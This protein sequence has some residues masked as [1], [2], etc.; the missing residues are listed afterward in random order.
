MYCM[1]AA[2]ESVHLRTAHN[3]TKM[4][5]CCAENAR[6]STLFRNDVIYKTKVPIC[7]FTNVHIVY[8]VVFLSKFYISSLTLVTLEEL[9]QSARSQSFSL[10]TTVNESSHIVRLW[11]SVKFQLSSSNSFRDMRGSQ[12]YT[13]GGVPHARP[14]AEKNLFP[15]NGIVPRL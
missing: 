9:K 12:I 10:V 8:T 1:N 11:R 7:H 13:R 4:R 14:L 5:S 2:S 15:K 6:H 3:T